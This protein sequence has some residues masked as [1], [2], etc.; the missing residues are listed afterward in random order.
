MDEALYRF[1]SV[2]EAEQR[3]SGPQKKRPLAENENPAIR[4]NQEQDMDKSINIQKGNESQP[5]A[6]GVEAGA[7]VCRKNPQKWE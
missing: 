1:Q 6:V 7:E 2:V 4:P 5:I 3:N